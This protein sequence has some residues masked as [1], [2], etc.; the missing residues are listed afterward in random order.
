MRRTCGACGKNQY[1]GSALGTRT[2]G[3][4]GCCC[5][6]AVCSAGG[7]C[8][9]LVAGCCCT[10]PG[11]GH[12]WSYA[13]GGTGC[14]ACPANTESQLGMSTPLSHC[15]SK[16]GFFGKPGKSATAC[17]PRSSSPA[18]AT[19]A[20]QCTCASGTFEVSRV[21]AVGP[22]CKKKKKNYINCEDKEHQHS[23]ERR[24]T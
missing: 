15:A 16:A 24:A 3:H 4:T 7:G 5:G 13:S 18:G 9:G 22:S 8:C 14:S 23:E 21:A 2:G 19:I 20:N 12:D 6:A 17:P 11:T 1:W 10:V